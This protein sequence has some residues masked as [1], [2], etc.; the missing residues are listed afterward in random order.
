MKL[1][2][3][4][5]RP[6]RV[7][8]T[9]PEGRHRDRE[10]G[11]AVLE[12]I[13]RHGL[14]CTPEW[15]PF[16]PNGRTENPEKARCVR[17]NRPHDKIV[18]SRACFT[19]SEADE[20]S[21]EYR[22]GPGSRPVTHTDLFGEFA[23]G[24]DPIEA[25]AL[26]LAPVTYYYRHHFADAG[27]HAGGPMAGLA[28]QFVERLDEL[29]ALVASLSHVEA[30]AHPDGGRDWE[31]RPRSWLDRV[32]IR[33]LHE[34]AVGT[35]LDGL[36]QDQAAQVY[37]LFDTDR[38]PAWNLYDFVLMMLFL[39]QTTDSTFE[40]AP[41]A[42]FQQREWRLVHHMMADQKWF[43]LATHDRERNPFAEVFHAATARVRACLDAGRPNWDAEHRTWFLNH[44]W[45]LAGVGPESD[46]VPF[47]EFVREIVVPET[48]VTRVEKLVQSVGF[49][50]PPVVTPLP[51][52][53]RLVRDGPLPRVV[54]VPEPPGG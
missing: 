7:G 8:A 27:P 21:K 38:L 46:H 2:H 34:A 3:A 18:Q 19:L 4:F 45:V 52:R 26:N 53:W 13:L 6:R 11:F 37:R 15:F 24:L 29:R 32:G 40:N 51:P 28:A 47:R 39:Y 16:Y 5:P 30:I 17:E 42:F 20:L 10:T 9:G 43:G 35:A 23:I 36:T 12:L 31:F 33:P 1:Y 48:C 14:L 44:S 49:R 41:L 54:A 22:V 25:R 50:R